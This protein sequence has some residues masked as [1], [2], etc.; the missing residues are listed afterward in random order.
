MVKCVLTC[1]GYWKR[2]LAGLKFLPAVRS[3]WRGLNQH[4]AVQPWMRQ[5]AQDHSCHLYWYAGVVTL[6]DSSMRSVARLGCAGSAKEALR[7]APATAGH[8]APLRSL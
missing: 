4:M 3:C 8:L 7:P 2:S 5:Y 6:Q 1:Y